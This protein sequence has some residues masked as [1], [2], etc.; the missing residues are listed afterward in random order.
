MWVCV[1]IETINMNNPNFILQMHTRGLFLR[2]H[3]YAQ[4]ALLDRHY[5]L[6]EMLA[7]PWIQ[8]KKIE[9]LHEG[10]G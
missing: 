5:D 9:L 10:D 1:C 4:D 2:H 3:V 7:Q 6:A 8:D